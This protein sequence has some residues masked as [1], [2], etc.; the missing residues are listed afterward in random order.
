[1]FL[2]PLVFPGRSLIVFYDCHEIT[3]L[4]LSIVSGYDY[5][6]PDVTLP[7]RP[8]TTTPAPVPITTPSAL[9]GAPP[10]GAPGGAPR[11]Q[12]RRG[13]RQGRRVRVEPATQQ[14]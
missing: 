5:P 9:Y 10:P 12:G 13:K 4:S 2:P 7:I 8:V 1:V 3:N 11:R 14:E 6:V